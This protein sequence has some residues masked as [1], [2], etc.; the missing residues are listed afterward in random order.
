[1]FWKNKLRYLKVL[2]FGGMREL[3]PGVVSRFS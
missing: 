1:M 2:G 3:A